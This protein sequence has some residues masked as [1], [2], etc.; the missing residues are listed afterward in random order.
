[1]K[2]VTEEL[3]LLGH[4]LQNVFGV[5]GNSPEEFEALFLRPE[6]YNQLA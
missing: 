5:I 4:T 6:E 2:G 1:M 3:E